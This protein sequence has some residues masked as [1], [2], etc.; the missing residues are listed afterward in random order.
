MDPEHQLWPVPLYWLLYHIYYIG[1]G[2][3]IFLTRYRY[4]TKIRE[5]LDWKIVLNKQEFF[6]F[7]LTN[8]LPKFMVISLDLIW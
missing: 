1:R 7:I 2:L 6:F 5:I 4:F 8:F 3:C